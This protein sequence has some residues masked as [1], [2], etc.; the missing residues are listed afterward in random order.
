MQNLTSDFMY[1][2]SEFVYP[3]AA[4]TGNTLVI[5][6]QMDGEP[7]SFI[8]GTGGDVTADDNLYQ[9]FTYDLTELF[10]EYDGIEEPVSHLTRMSVYPNPA[11]NQLNVTLSQN[12][13]I[14]IYNIMGQVVM[15]V[16]GRVGVNSINISE[17]NAGIYFVS[18]GSETQKFIVK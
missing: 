8:I 13:G 11:V 3:Q 15:N 1:S 16:E 17:L 12:A 6:A 2:L 18:A 9:A 10:E 5:A 7:D 4:I 14:V